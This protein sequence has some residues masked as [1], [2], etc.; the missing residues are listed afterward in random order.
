MS[1]DGDDGSVVDVEVPVDEEE[2]Q[3]ERLGEDE[4]EEALAP[5]ALRDPGEPTRREREEH[6]LTHQPPRPWCR[7]CMKGRGQH[8]QHR[9]EKKDEDPGDAAVPTI[10]LDYTFMGNKWTNASDNPVLVLY[11]HKTKA[12]GAWQVYRKGAVDWVVK[13]VNQFI[14]SLGY[15]SV[16]VVL[17]SD[18]EPSIVALKDAIG[19]MRRSPTVN[20]ETSVRDSKANGA[21]EVRIKTWQAQFRTMLLDLQECIGRRVPLGSN[22]TSWLVNW[23]AVSL[24]RYKLDNAGRTSY[25]RVTGG[26]QKRPI[27]KFGEK[28]WWM[29]NGKRNAG[30]KADSNVHEGIFVGLKNQMV[31]SMIATKDGVI[32]ARTIRKMPESER[33]NAEDVLRIK[34]SVAAN[35]NNGEDPRVYAETVEQSKAE[36]VSASDSPPVSGEQSEPQPADQEDDAVVF[37]EGVQDDSR[38]DIDADYSPTSP[39]SPIIP[40]DEPNQDQ[41]RTMVD[42]AGIPAGMEEDTT[43]PTTPPSRA[44]LR[45]LRPL[46]TSMEDDTNSPDPT[47]PRGSKSQRTA[48]E[49]DDEDGLMNSLEKEVEEER[50]R[51]DKRMLAL[52]INGVDVSEIY[53]PPRVVDMAVRMGLIGGSSMDLKTG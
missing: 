26:A 5:K 22:A 9:T 42:D 39:G 7:H 12:I 32:A 6:D 14:N 45:R 19:R 50:N 4:P 16:R 30:E 10:S 53:S 15:G 20:V 46:R 8:D 18:G 13:E 3:E 48:Q 28:V 27:A 11:D 2:V 31:D 35:L 1:E 43:E 47:Q 49:L 40:D 29:P 25:H 36:P 23:A 33:W 34:F 21:V 51:V 52:M 38:I 41:E 24:N 17:R 44:P 37:E